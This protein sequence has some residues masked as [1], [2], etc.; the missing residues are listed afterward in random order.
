ML[1]RFIDLLEEHLA[2]VGV[3]GLIE[4]LLGIIALGGALSIVFG[5][6]TIKAAAVVAIML[7]VLGLFV[8]LVASRV[9]LRRQSDLDRRLL[10]RYCKVLSDEF[11]IS[12]KLMGWDQTIVIGK[13]G[14]ARQT[15]KV[16]AVV[17]SKRL[18]YYRVRVGP[19]WNQP[20]KYR[21]KVK[22]QVRS[23]SIEGVS[24][25]RS[26]VTELWLEDGTLE[27]LVHFPSSVPRGAEFHVIVVLDWPGK[28]RPLMKDKVPDDFC[29]KLERSNVQQ[30]RYVIV[31]PSGVD[32]SYDPIGFSLS[33]SNF[34]LIGKRNGGD[35]LEIALVATDIKATGRK[36]IGVRLDL[37]E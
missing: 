7:G 23:L 10:V 11:P 19:G 8:I 9:S 14:D 28:C 32:A 17:E 24:G 35:Q 26:E 15:I 33:D 1:R 18:S 21:K 16:H 2:D 29:Y 5:N 13:N 22:V 31:L 20:Q 6:T 37:N 27:I 25:T 3:I 12:W 36:R 34:S 4:A 30:F